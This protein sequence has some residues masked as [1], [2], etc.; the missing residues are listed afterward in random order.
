M[1]VRLVDAHM[2]GDD[3]IALDAARRLSAFA[4][5][6]EARAMEMGFQRE[7]GRFGNDRPSYFPFLRQLPELLADQE[8]QGEGI[9]ARADPAARGRPRGPGRRADPRPGP[10]RHPP[11]GALRQRRHSSPLVRALIAEGDAA[12]EPLLAAIESDTRLTRTVT[13]GRGMSIDRRVH[14]VVEPEFAALTAILKTQQ[15]RGQAYQV[16]P[17]RRRGRSWR[18]RCA[19][20]G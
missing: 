1:F 13:Y 19:T 11:A 3:A 4:T 6:A 2:R 7:P 20:S 9:A 17:A 16:G 8:R 15:F 10:D 14:P 18:G 12:V 5:A